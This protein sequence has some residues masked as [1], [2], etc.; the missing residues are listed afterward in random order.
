L[1]RISEGCYGIC[2]ISGKK[3]PQARLEA[4][5]FARLTVE[6]QSQ[7]EQEHPNRQFRA[8]DALGFRGASNGTPAVSLDAPGE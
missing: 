7:W 8:I 2:E 6:C 1:E 3:I 5:P 4:I